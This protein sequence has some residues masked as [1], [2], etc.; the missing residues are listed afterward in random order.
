MVWNTKTSN[1]LEYYWQVTCW[2]TNTSTSC[3]RSV[4]VVDF[5]TK[6]RQFRLGLTAG[7]SSRPGTVPGYTA[8]AK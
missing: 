5:A 2:N 8:K 1:V 6:E 4:P 3:S 7:R